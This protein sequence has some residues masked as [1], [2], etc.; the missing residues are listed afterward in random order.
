M[1]KT[2][3]HEKYIDSPAEPNKPPPVG[4]G[5]GV[6]PNE[7]PP[8]GA[9]VVVDD[10]APPN[11][12]PPVEG[13]G[14]AGV[15]PKLKPPGAG[16]GA[17]GAAGAGVEPKLKAMVYWLVDNRRQNNYACIDVSVQFTVRETTTVIAVGK[18]VLMLC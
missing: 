3:I 6:D 11:E 2:K 10:D 17:P 9:G 18:F 4:A 8:A 7:P 5:A 16:V 15:P 1:T 14:A 12:N 13:A